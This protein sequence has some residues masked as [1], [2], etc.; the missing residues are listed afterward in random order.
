MTARSCWKFFFLK[1]PPPQ[2]KK[3]LF[4]LF[5]VLWR[6]NS[7]FRPLKWFFTSK[8]WVLLNSSAWPSQVKGPPSFKHISYPASTW[9]HVACRFCVRDKQL[10]DCGLV[11][12]LPSGGLIFW[13]DFVTG[14]DNLLFPSWLQFRFTPLKGASHCVAWF[15]K[16]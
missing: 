6:I 11:H 16:A 2:K 4:F 7:P 14:G 8:E 13:C 15:D 12:P 9:N 10:F 1:R 3:I 5:F